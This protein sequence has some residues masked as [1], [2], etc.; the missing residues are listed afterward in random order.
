MLTT[1]R[2]AL[3]LAGRDRRARWILLILLAL[4][5]TGFEAAAAVL[6]YVLLGLVSGVDDALVLPVVGDVSSRLGDREPN[7]VLLPAVTAIAVFFLLRAGVLVLQ[8]YVE[9]RVLENAGAAL[10]A[11]LLRGYL[12]MPY[13]FHTR[14]NSAELIRNAHD[15]AREVTRDVFATCLLLVTEALLVLGILV[16]LVVTEPLATLLAAA[17]L[18]PVLYLLLKVVHPR[19]KTLGRTSQAMHQASLQA[20]QQSLEGIRDIKVTGSE[21]FF[22]HG[23]VRSRR[24]LARAQ[25]LRGLLSRLPQVLM[26]TTLILAIVAAFGAAVAFGGTALQ[27]LPV[28]GLFAYAAMRLKPSLN[29]I[30]ASLNATRFATVALEQLDSDLRQVEQHRTSSRRP[31]TRLPFRSELRVDDVSFRYDPAGPDVLHRISFTVRPGESIGIV[32]P[33]GGGKS[34]LVDVLLGLLEPTGGHV[35]VDDT[36]LHD[37]VR[38]WQANLGVVPQALFLL[39]DSLRRNVALGVDDRDI[40]EDR[41][42]EVVRLAQ[43]D[44]CVA[45]LPAGIDTVIGE[46]GI[47]LSGGQRQRVAIARAL[48]RRPAVLV[49]DEGT[50][51]LDNRTEA[52]LMRALTDLR[53]RHTLIAVAHR[54]TT[55]RGCDRVLVIDHGRIVA[56][57]TYEELATAEGVFR[58]L[59]VPAGIEASSPAPAG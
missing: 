46:R 32:G 1:F 4:V 51:A 33:T 39:D 7:E 44:D 12:D 23:F 53:G 20:L 43:L 55:V 59:L 13:A 11:R 30:V 29:R 8:T 54:L 49:F 35:R 26:E 36:D 15:T 22:V 17:T 25:Y 6:I 18:G 19:L 50:S 56:T 31:A 40:D 24:E 3:R 37:D 21:R 14:R 58:R 52:E 2:R 38:G 10:S 42:R 48:Y 45:E 27:A 41:V 57:G 16:V 5:V 47:R 9:R 34:T 28:L